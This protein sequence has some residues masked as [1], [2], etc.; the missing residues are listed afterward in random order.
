MKTLALTSA[1][2]LL[3][4]SNASGVFQIFDGN[5]EMRS[6]LTP[7]L[8]DSN[9]P[10]ADFRCDGPASP[11]HMFGSNW[12][13][14]APGGGG[15][16]GFSWLDT[17]VQTT[18]GNTLTLVYT[19]AGPNPV[20]VNR[21]NA[22]LTVQIFDAVQPNTARCESTLEFQA[23]PTNAGP[24]VWNIFHVADLD[25]NGTAPNDIAQMAPAIPDVP[26]VIGEAVS[27]DRI[28]FIGIN[29]SRWEVNTGPV[30]RNK[31][32]GGAVLDLSGA[33]GPVA[34]DGAY[35]YQWVVTLAPGQSARFK[36]AFGINMPPL[37][38][39]CPGDINAD[40]A[41]DVN[42]LVAFLASFGQVVPPFSA[43]DLD[44]NGLVNVVDLTILLGLFGQPC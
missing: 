40:G 1:A 16:R 21:F 3:V 22:R 38:P 13:Y 30:L 34:G 28:T 7:F 11:D 6:A 25:L 27:P 18:I 17:P 31:I 43:G 44:G 14:R 36:T 41:R 9:L 5:A 32:V 39:P 12:A 37:P 19:N 2:V 33:V 29:P 15:N 23:A 8:P 4:S 10:T 42:D 35:G 24:T 20:G 26:G